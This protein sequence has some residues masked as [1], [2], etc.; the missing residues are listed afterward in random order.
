MCVRE[1]PFLMTS[2]KF[3]VILTPPPGPTLS[4]F[5]TDWYFKFTQP[6]L[7]RLLFLM[8]S[9][10]LEAL[11]G[12]LLPSRRLHVTRHDLNHPPQCWN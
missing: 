8:R 10:Y 5:G 6:L 9:P 1:L 2:V 11:L 3:S 4:A 12:E 7:L